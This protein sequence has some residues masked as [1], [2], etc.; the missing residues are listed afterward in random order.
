MDDFIQFRDTNGFL[1]R[2]SERHIVELMEFGEILR[3]FLP[4]GRMINVRVDSE[5]GR[6][7]L[8]NYRTFD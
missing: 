8:S 4:D 6:Y 2:V 5:V 3:L 1:R 7:L